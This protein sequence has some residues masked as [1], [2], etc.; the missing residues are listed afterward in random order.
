LDLLSTFWGA[1]HD[2]ALFTV[3]LLTYQQ[4]PENSPTPGG[5]VFTE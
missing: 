1:V 5:I 4:G 2:P 3:V